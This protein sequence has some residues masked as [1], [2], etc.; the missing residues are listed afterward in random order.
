MGAYIYARRGGL[1]AKDGRAVPE[2]WGETAGHAKD[3]GEGVYRGLLDAGGEREDGVQS[4][5]SGC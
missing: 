1:S 5:P 3:V 4:A 2:E